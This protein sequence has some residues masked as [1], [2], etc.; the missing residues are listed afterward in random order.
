[1]IPNRRAASLRSLK[2]LRTWVGPTA[3][4]CGWTFRFGIDTNRMRALAQES[5]GLQP[6]VILTGGTPATAALQRETQ[7]IPIVFM[8][9]VD[10]V[11]SGIN[12][13]INASTK[14][15]SKSNGTP[16]SSARSSKPKMS[17]ILVTD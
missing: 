2:R 7:T 5:V 6:D 1:M 11:A 15:C 14:S 4:R 10:P 17:P 13:C 9:A 16:P 12:R 3:A 8:T